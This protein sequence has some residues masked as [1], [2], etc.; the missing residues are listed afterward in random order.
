MLVVGFL[1]RYLDYHF[2]FVFPLL[3]RG[4]NGREFLGRARVWFCNTKGGEMGGMWKVEGKWEGDI[5][6]RQP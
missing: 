6:I 1:I 4:G 3:G 5:S 2:Q